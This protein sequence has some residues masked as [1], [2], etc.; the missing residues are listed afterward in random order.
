ME[1]TIVQET[2]QDL[3]TPRRSWSMHYV[4]LMQAR[5]HALMGAAVQTDDPALKRVLM[6]TWRQAERRSEE[7][8][9]HLSQRMDPEVPG[10]VMKQRI[11]TL[12]ARIARLGKGGAGC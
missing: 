11:L 4:E 7:A 12:A 1:Q 8:L 3:A 6:L 9:L 2:Q 10:T 5:A